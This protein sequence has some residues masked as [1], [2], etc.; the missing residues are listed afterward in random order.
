MA[1][2]VMNEMLHKGP[3]S[4]VQ[5]KTSERVEA[6]RRRNEATVSCY[7]CGIKTAQVAPIA[8]ADG[9]IVD[10]NSGN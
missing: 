6:P 7:L 1:V 2:W 8:T 9:L 4:E 3:A 10:S 5:K